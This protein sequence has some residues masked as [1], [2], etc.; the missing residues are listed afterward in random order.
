MALIVR[1]IIHRVV[2]MEKSIRRTLSNYLARR[3]P[4]LGLC[5][6]TNF[7]GVLNHGHLRTQNSIVQLAAL[8]ECSRVQCST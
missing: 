6:V 4:G 8:G 3:D 1:I 5:I 2:L 7:N